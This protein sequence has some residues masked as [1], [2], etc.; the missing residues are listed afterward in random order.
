M[1]GNCFFMGLYLTG[2][3]RLSRAPESRGTQRTGLKQ[4]PDMDT[5]GHY[6]GIENEHA[7]GERLRANFV[8]KSQ[9]SLS[10][11]SSDITTT[12]FLHL[13]RAPGIKVC[14]DFS[15]AGTSLRVFLVFFKAGKVKTNSDLFSMSSLVMLHT[16]EPGRTSL[17]NTHS[18][19]LYS[20][21]SS[22][23]IISWTNC[24]SLWQ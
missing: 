6:G 18:F 17:S 24:K 4:R 3:S 23:W 14:V 11:Y 12:I 20:V 21:C 1:L 15:S 19:S 22:C 5:A 9:A 13:H 16:Q 8:W 7:P 10:R 2:M